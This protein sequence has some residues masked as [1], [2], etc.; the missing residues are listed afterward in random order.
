MQSIQGTPKKKKTVKKLKQLQC[1]SYQLNLYQTNYTTE[2]L[3]LYRE[4]YRCA[5]KSQGCKATK[6]IQVIAENPTTY[7]IVYCGQHSC[8]KDQTL[9]DE[10][11]PVKSFERD[12]VKMLNISCSIESSTKL[13]RVCCDGIPTSSCLSNFRGQK[14]MKKIHDENKP[15][16]PRGQ[17]QNVESSSDPTAMVQLKETPLPVDADAGSLMLHP[18]MT[19]PYFVE[20]DFNY[21]VTGGDEPENGFLEI[22]PWD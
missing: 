10:I 16:K 7:R 21:L 3:N 2:V 15:C 5:L 6:K 4:Y 9:G 12:S 17:D 13:R 14:Q 19:S 11:R 8:Q 22:R 18:S 1:P 20:E